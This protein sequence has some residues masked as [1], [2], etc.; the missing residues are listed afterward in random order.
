MKYILPHLTAILFGAIISTADDRY[1]L[2]AVSNGH[3]AEAM[4]RRAKAEGELL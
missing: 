2:T 3:I 1:K 4:Y